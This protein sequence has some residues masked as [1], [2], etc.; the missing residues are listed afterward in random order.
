MAV[1]SITS[2]FW[3]SHAFNSIMH[4][5]DEAVSVAVFNRHKLLVSAFV[6]KWP[7][8]SVLSNTLQLQMFAKVIGYDI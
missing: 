8:L 1:K 7:S 6:E 4:G 2:Q 5:F 3:N